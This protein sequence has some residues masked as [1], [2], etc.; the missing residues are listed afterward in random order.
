MVSNYI[1]FL[2]SNNLQYCNNLVSKI[3]LLNWFEFSSKNKVVLFSY[4]MLGK[5]E[6]TT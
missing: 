1:P 2:V 6:K 3:L 5:H 4:I